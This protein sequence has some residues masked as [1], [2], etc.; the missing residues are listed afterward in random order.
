[1][2]LNLLKIEGTWIKKKTQST[3]A[4]DMG[5]NAGQRLLNKV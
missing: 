1:M 5:S 2:N 3:V 4:P